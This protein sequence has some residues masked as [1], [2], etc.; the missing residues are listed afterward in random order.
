[1][2]F[3]KWKTHAWDYKKMSK[4]T[5]KIKTAPAICG[6]GVSLIVFH[7]SKRI[8]EKPTCKRCLRM[9]RTKR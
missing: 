8:K 5:E 6:S 3:R 7:R 2:R 4:L 9:L 1:V